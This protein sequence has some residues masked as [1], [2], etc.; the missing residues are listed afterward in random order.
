MYTGGRLDAPPKTFDGTTNFTAT[1]TI[2]GMSTTCPI[3]CGYGSGAPAN[4]CT[5]GI[6]NFIKDVESDSTPGP[7]QTFCCETTGISVAGDVG[8]CEAVIDK[9][10]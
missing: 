3:C 10:A 5:T 8:S 4:N 7:A 6:A 1:E 9:D 2:N